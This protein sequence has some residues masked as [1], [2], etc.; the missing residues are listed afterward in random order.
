MDLSL[1]LMC[2]RQR[3]GFGCITNWWK[4]GTRHPACPAQV[5]FYCS[6][7]SLLLVIIVYGGHGLVAGTGGRRAGSRASWLR[8][9]L[10]PSTLALRITRCY[11]FLACRAHCTK[12]LWSF[13]I[14]LYGRL[15][16]PQTSQREWAGSGLG[17]ALCSP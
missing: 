9:A 14:W 5:R 12:D 8:P 10:L 2:S 6:P 7:P 3:P 15:H 11:S 1:L 13:A 16:D 4:M 17:P